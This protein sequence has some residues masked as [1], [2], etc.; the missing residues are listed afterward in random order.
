MISSRTESSLKF[1]SLAML[2]KL[3]PPKKLEEV[4]VLPF[5]GKADRQDGVTKMGTSRLLKRTSPP[6][7]QSAV[8]TDGGVSAKGAH[9]PKSASRTHDIPFRERT[10]STIFHTVQPARRVVLER[11]LEKL[12]I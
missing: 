9:T 12:A 6:H 3:S 1:G 2:V 11:M 7:N 10:F 5:I 4:T 8:Q